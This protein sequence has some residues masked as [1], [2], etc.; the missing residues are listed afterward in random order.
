MS[1][2]LNLN[3]I[4][5]VQLTEH[6]GAILPDGTTGFSIFQPVVYPDSDTD[7]EEIVDSDSDDTEDYT[8]LDHQRCCCGSV[9]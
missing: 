7:D 4:F 1:S 2:K 5:V 8:T 9:R 6:S 3:N